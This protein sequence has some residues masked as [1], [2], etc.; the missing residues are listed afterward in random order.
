MK[1]PVS[2]KGVRSKG[3]P[4]WR[5]SIQTHR[6]AE[7]A[8]VE[9]CRA[10]FPEPPVS[11]T[12]ADTGRVA[13]NVYV[14]KPVG[15]AAVVLR[16]RSG[17]AVIRRSGLNAGSGKISIR[18]I[19]HRD[20][21]E[22]WRRHF[23]PLE[24]GSALL[25][26]PSWSR[27][28]PR[29]GQ[30]VVVLDPGLSFGTGQHPTTAFCLRQVAACR[31]PRRPQSFLDIGTGSGILAIA[32][33]KLGYSPVE[34]FDNDPVAVR[35]ARDN[36]RRNGV[37]GK[38]RIHRERAGQG[39]E[40]SRTE[41]RSDLREPGFGRFNFGMPSD[42]RAVEM[43]RDGGVGGHPEKRICPGIR[44]LPEGGVEAHWRPVGE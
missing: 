34:A 1:P 33:A 12:D 17:F 35:R 39:R 43:G 2:R 36:A 9:L 23:K 20:W 3:G 24:V 29:A 19:P 5:I 38:V 18:K 25:V 37:A 16:I 26:K 30:A 31:D 44:S 41:A 10:I 8:V 27:R 22:S 15:R 28:R 4:L 21:A 42:R 6:E 32:A 7:E 11:F 14:G 13:V 40:A